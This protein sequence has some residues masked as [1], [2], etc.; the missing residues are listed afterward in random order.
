MGIVYQLDKRTGI[1][2][3]YSN[4]AKWNKEKKRSES[5]RRLLGR[6]VNLETMEYVPT[7]GRCRGRSPYLTDG[8]KKEAREKAEDAAIAKMKKKDL[9]QEVKRLRMENKELLERI[10]AYEPGNGK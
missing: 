1:T 10:S 4:E 7:D 5:K 9:V 8:E 3:A 6:V 2:Y